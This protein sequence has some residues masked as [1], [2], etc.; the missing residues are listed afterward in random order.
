MALM[1]HV[2]AGESGGAGRV[3]YSHFVSPDTLLNASATVTIGEL[4]CW[5]QSL[6]ATILTICADISLPFDSIPSNRISANDI[7]NTPLD[8]TSA[9]A[10]DLSVMGNYC[11]TECKEDFSGW[12]IE[13]GIA[14]GSVGR[15]LT[16][17]GSTVIIAPNS[18]YPCYC[19]SIGLGIKLG[20]KEPPSP[21]SASGSVCY[22]WLID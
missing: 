1:S 3:K 22:T 17:G 19:S 11:F 14:V 8:P 4:T 21:V 12:T 7:S 6:S 20:S 2:Q 9:F 16:T 10:I 18:E 13:G 15:G 5:G